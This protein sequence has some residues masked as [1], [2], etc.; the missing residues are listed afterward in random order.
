MFLACL[1]GWDFPVFVRPPIG[2]RHPW[3]EVFILL[4]PQVAGDSAEAADSIL[5]RNLGVGV[6]HGDALQ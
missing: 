2:W 4:N 3:F 5:G 6:K 1:F